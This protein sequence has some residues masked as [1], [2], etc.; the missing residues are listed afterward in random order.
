MLEVVYDQKGQVMEENLI[1]QEVQ[2]NQLYFILLP[3]CNNISFELESRVYMKV[4]LYL[5]CITE[6]AICGAI[7]RISLS[8]LR[9]LS[10][11][12]NSSYLFPTLL[13]SVK[14]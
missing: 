13:G 2:I 9:R 1:V 5:V 6:Q 7:S 11:W 10:T 12:Q 4:Y 3:A 14:L 8:F